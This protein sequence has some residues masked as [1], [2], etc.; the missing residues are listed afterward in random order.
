MAPRTSPA[1]AISA[2]TGDPG[3]PTSPRWPIGGAH[4]PLCGDRLRQGTLLCRRHWYRVTRATRA[5]VWAAY[6]AWL[7]ERLDLAGL[8]KVQACAVDEARQ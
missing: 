1:F 4:C 5:A 2:L 6:E 3:T 7:A 8:R